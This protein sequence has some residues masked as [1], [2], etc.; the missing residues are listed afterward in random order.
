MTLDTRPRRHPDTRFR[1]I[2]GEAIVILPEKMELRILS[3]TGS[4]IWD[5]ID[6]ERSVGAMVDVVVEEFAVER[7]VAS[8]DVISFLQELAGHG[9]VSLEGPGSS[10]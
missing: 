5:L 1:V 4:R 6:G 3:E 2:E 9:L 10:E 7:D 8:A